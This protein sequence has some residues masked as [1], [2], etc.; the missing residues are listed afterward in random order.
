M[1]WTWSSQV[2]S[3][4]QRDEQNRSPR[5]SASNCIEET[6]IAQLDSRYCR[7]IIEPGESVTNEGVTAAE[8]G[9][10]N[11]VG[12]RLLATGIVLGCLL[13]AA[14]G[15]TA[16]TAPS[17]Q[18]SSSSQPNASAAP[19]GAAANAACELVT[20]QEASHLA[21]VSFGACL[22]E[23]RNDGGYGGWAAG[24][25][26]VMVELPLGVTPAEIPSAQAEAQYFMVGRMGCGNGAG[27][28]NSV[29]V[30]GAD[31]AA[32]AEVSCVRPAPFGPNGQPT[33]ARI[34]YVEKGANAF[35]IL[36]MVVSHPAANAA[37][38]EAQ[39]K[40][41]LGRLPEAIQLACSSGVSVVGCP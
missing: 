15:S 19:S 24:D 2:T 4:A 27:S 29:T 25:N 9:R 34:I 30:P 20:S 22:P 41:S 8:E 17:S 12:G 7:P 3:S 21:G 23:S 26:L 13:L 6:P 1:R 10:D 38:L 31:R 16:S 40:I 5:G 14:C 32:T 11:P 35:W 36:N 37:A 18:P 39:A 33:Y 28:S